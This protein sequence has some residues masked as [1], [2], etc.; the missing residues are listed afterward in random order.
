MKAGAKLLG[1]AFKKSL[2]VCKEHYLSHLEFF[3]GYIYGYV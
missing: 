1:V 2:I 3:V